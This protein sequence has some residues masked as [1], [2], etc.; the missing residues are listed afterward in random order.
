MLNAKIFQNGRSQAVRLPKEY[1]F[2]ES[3]VIAHKVGEVLML[4]PKSQ[5]DSWS[6]L[7]ASL[8]MFSDD[9][10]AEGRDDSRQQERELL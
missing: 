6:T 3:E 2:T 4:M 8:D 5:A 9:F 7:L 10:M 1:R